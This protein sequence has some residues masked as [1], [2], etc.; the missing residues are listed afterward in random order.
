[1]TEHRRQLSP[2]DTL[3]TAAI[4]DAGLSP[5]GSRVVYSVTAEPPD[6]RT[7]T[8]H[9]CLIDV[10]S[11]TSR[12][13][14]TPGKLDLAPVWAPDGSGVFF[15]SNRGE[16]GLQLFRVAVDGG[17]PEQLTEL[18]GGV[19]LATPAVSPGGHRVAFAGRDEAAPDTTRPYRVR[20]KLWRLDTVGRLD[21]AA[22]GVQVLDL[23]TGAVRA[24]PGDPRVVTSLAWSPDGD[25]LLQVSFAAS[26]DPVFS[27][28]VWDARTG[29]TT[30][31]WQEEFL[32]FPPRVAWLPDGRLVRTTDNT[33]VARGRPMD[34]AVVEAE[35]GAE[36]RLLPT[37]PGWLFGYLQHDVPSTSF[38]ASPIV[39][40]GSG[41]EVYVAVQSGGSIESRAVPLNGSADPRTVVDGE[42]ATVPLD[43]VGNDVLVATSTLHEPPDLWL[44]GADGK[45]A[46]RLTRLNEDRFGSQRHFDVR[47]LKVTGLDGAPVEAW[48]LAPKT[49]DGPVKTVLMA[50][51]GPHAAWGNAFLMD[52]C[53]LTDAGYGVLLANS[54]GSIGYEPSFAE[55]LHGNYGSHDTAD[56]LCAVDVAVGEGLAAPDRLAVWGASGGGYLAAWMISH[57]DRFKAAVVESPHLDW[58]IQFGADVGWFFTDYLELEPGRGVGGADRIAGW[59]P[60]WFAAAC[61]TPTLIV[62][63]EADLRT[64][65]AN[66]DLL[67]NL[68]KMHGCETEMLRMPGGSWHAGSSQLGDPL[69]R[70]VQNE[71]M[72][73]WF[74]RFLT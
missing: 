22:H 14:T 30:E 69:A 4:L 54:R 15:V 71:S 67:F 36:Q 19:S 23:D 26:D 2:D 64:P 3:R 6:Q 9:L 60:T 66:S 44:V 68:L 27:V 21:A 46:R 45:N 61:T 72:L 74:D 32:L 34:L 53:L 8:V 57:G 56:L 5:D 59:S 43:A 37:G 13:L 52:A 33:V 18:V 31:L 20:S 10:P 39:V 50:H 28:E 42:Q 73:E 63:H 35:P 65:A 47:P 7:E 55:Q 1:M 11:A 40:S 38:M 12:D 17:E 25:R 51:G 49:A 62:Q 16:G 24:L 58:M 41:D 29:R 48:F 70:V